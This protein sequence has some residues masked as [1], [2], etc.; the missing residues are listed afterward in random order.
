MK[1][2]ECPICLSLKVVTPGWHTMLRTISYDIYGSDSQNS[3]KN[4]IIAEI[5]KKIVL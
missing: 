2:G 5:R 3:R 4:P 1:L